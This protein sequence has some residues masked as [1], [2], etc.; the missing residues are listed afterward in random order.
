MLAVIGCCFMAGWWGV[1]GLPG[2]IWV[3]WGAEQFLYYLP[4]GA[5]LGWVGHKLAPEDA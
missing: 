2:N 4:G 3:W 5:V 1:F